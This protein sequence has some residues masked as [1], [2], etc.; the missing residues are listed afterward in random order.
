MTYTLT[1]DLIAEPQQAV[2]G[3]CLADTAQTLAAEQAARF[4]SIEERLAR[5]EAH[6]WPPWA[7]TQKCP[8]RCVW[9][10]GGLLS[11]GGKVCLPSRSSAPA[12]TSAV[13]AGT[14]RSRAGRW[15]K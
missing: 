3:M 15:A 8:P 1:Q 14:G 13:R 5:I 11:D 4:D 9:P 6:L 10:A 7:R 2:A 12:T